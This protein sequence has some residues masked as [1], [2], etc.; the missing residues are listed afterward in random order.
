M[1]IH[2]FLAVALA[3]VPSPAMAQRVT[4]S[5]AA[6]AVPAPV[7]LDN[8]G[9]FQAKLARVGT[10]LY[11]AGQPTADALRQLHDQGVTTVVNLRTPEEMATIGFDEAALVASLGMKYV[12]LPVRGG[13]PYPYSPE[14]VSSFS[15]AM[16]EA[17]GGVLLHCTVAWRASHLWAAYLIQE[18]G[19][20]VDTAL[21][22]AR[23]INLMA[24]HPMVDGRQPVEDFLGRDL[25][26]LRAPRTP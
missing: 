20:P 15:R 8:T 11:I 14:T 24:D 12:Y 5:D 1:R 3:T 18:R 4:G 7:V 17:T 10:D 2:P 22:R 19:M 26:A 13:N 25:S 9:R 16:K 23:L 21:A 6:K